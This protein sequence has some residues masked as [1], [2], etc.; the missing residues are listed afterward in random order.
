MKNANLK[1]NIITI[2]LLIAFNS[3][4]QIIFLDESPIQFELTNSYNRNIKVQIKNVSDTTVQFKWELITPELTG[5]TLRYSI[6]DLNIGY[7]FGTLT[8][9]DI[10]MENTL[11][12]DQSGIIGVSFFSDGEIPD[13]LL[14]TIVELQFN[15]LNPNNCEEIFNSITISN[16][17]TLNDSELISTDQFFIFPNPVINEINFSN[18]TE[19]SSYEIYNT[20]LKKVKVGDIK[21]S[22]PIIVSEILSGMYYL[23]L[24]G[25]NQNIIKPFIKK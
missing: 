23:K 14:N 7:P 18:T 4:S 22:N 17:S 20:E 19:F 15:I 13:S 9:C 11:M 12:A 5:I 6:S 3:N 21:E 24:I 16:E 8:T 25:D 1:L 2:L 10:N